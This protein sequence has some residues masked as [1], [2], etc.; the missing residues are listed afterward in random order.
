MCTVVLVTGR[1]KYDYCETVGELAE[2]LRIDPVAIYTIINSDANEILQDMCL[3]PIDLEALGAR[4]ATDQEGNPFP[5]YIIELPR[6]EV[7][8][9]TR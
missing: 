9:G 4:P 5:E 1:G 2:A 3:C 6:Q 8:D 7:K